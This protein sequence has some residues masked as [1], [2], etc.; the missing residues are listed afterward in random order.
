MQKDRFRNG[1]VAE[2]VVSDF[3]MSGEGIVKFGAYPVFV[4]F[5]VVGETVRIRIVHAKKDYAFGELIEVLISSKDR[6]KP[7]CRYFGRCGGC[8]LQHLSAP[9][10][11]E[12]KRLHL[13]R[14]LQKA[15]I[16]VTVPE[17]FKGAE[18]AYRNKLA[19]PFGSLGKHGKV[20]LGDRK[21]VV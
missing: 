6:I 13:Q 14:T 21:S 4:P 20:V 12:I 1:D 18:W 3:G 17:V 15:G 9:M 19:L 8:D 5:A 11:E 2:G 16:D 10:Q 7:R